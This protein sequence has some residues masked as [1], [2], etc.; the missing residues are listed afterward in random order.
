M[1]KSGKEKQVCPCGSF[2]RPH[3]ALSVAARSLHVTERVV[4]GLQ[5]IY[6]CPHCVIEFAAWTRGHAN[7]NEATRD[8]ILKLAAG[9]IAAIWEEIG[10]LVPQITS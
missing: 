6:I 4:T 9:S 10:G 1:P 3:I 2:A 8:R 7:L 5:T